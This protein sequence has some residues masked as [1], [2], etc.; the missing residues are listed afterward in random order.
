M[1]SFELLSNL[2]NK[3]TDGIYVSGDEKNGEYK[4]WHK[5]GQLFVHV[6]YKDGKLNGEYKQWYDNGQLFSH[7][8]YND[9]EI[10]EE[11]V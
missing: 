4:E 1:T 3:K 6:F 2:T 10:V 7:Y 8:L 5:N 9:G 11:Y